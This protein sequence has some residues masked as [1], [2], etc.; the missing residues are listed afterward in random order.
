[1]E[2]PLAPRGGLAKPGVNRILNLAQR[3]SAQKI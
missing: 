1:M 2:P 3:R